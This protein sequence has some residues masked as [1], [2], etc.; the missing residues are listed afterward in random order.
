MEHNILWLPL[1][2]WYLQVVITFQITVI[3]NKNQVSISPLNVVITFQITVIPNLEVKTL[4]YA[5]AITSQFK[6]WSL[7]TLLFIR[8]SSQ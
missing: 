7:P 5:V 2:Y 1:K 8:F 6:L 3:P 4:T